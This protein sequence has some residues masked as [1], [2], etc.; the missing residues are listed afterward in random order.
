MT[1][2]TTTHTAN[3]GR[4]EKYQ[5]NLGI[6]CEETVLRR[7]FQQKPLFKDVINTQKKQEW[8]SCTSWFYSQLMIFPYLDRKCLYH[9]FTSRDKKSAI[10]LRNSNL[11][12]SWCFRNAALSHYGCAF[13][14]AC[15][16][17]P[18]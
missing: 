3:L 11:N 13:H 12:N 18:L 2:N 5:L 15:S 6:Q 1:P 4:G 9:I 8:I 14:I 10:L 7:N 17:A 16:A